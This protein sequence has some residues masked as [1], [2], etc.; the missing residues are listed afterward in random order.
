MSS[1]L[2]GCD[3]TW[4]GIHVHSDDGIPGTLKLSGTIADE[5]VSPTIVSDA[6]IAI[7]SSDASPVYSILYDDDGN[8]IVYSPEPGQVN[9]GKL[10]ITRT[11]FINNLQVLHLQDGVDLVDVS[12]F[13]SCLFEVNDA[14]Y[15]SFDYSDISQ[16][17]AKHVFLFQ[18]QNLD[19]VDCE[20]RNDMTNEVYFPELWL[21][22]GRAIQSVDAKFEVNSSLLGSGSSFSGFYKGIESTN[23][24]SPWNH[25]RIIKSNF[26]DNQIA[27]HFNNVCWHDVIQNTVEVGPSL[28]LPLELQEA[29]VPYEGIFQQMGAYFII[30]EN[31]IAGIGEPIDNEPFVGIRIRDTGARDNEVYRNFL[32]DLTRG[33]QAEGDNVGSTAPWDQFGLRFVCNEF[34]DCEFDLI[35]ANNGNPTELSWEQFGL[36][37]DDQGM[38]LLFEDEEGLEDFGRRG[39]NSFTL[40]TSP[41]LTATGNWHNEGS[42]LAYWCG[43]ESMCPA[44]VDN[45]GLDVSLDDGAAHNCPTIPVELVSGMQEVYFQ[46]PADW[47]L[48]ENSWNAVVE[49]HEYILSAI[50]DGGDSDELQEEV[51]FAWVDDTWVMREDLLSKSPFLSSDV[52]MRVADNTVTF[53]HAIAFEIFAANPD[54]LRDARFMEHLTSKSEPLPNY[55]VDLLYLS[56]DQHTFRTAIESNIALANASAQRVRSLSHRIELL[57][58]EAAMLQLNE[59]MNS[60]QLFD[61]KLKTQALSLAGYHAEAQSALSGASFLRLSQVDVDHLNSWV[62]YINVELTQADWVDPKELTSTQWTALQDLAV[63]QSRSWGGQTAGSFLSIH[64]EDDYYLRPSPVNL[65]PRI[66]DLGNESEYLEQIGLRPNPASYEVTIELPLHWVSNDSKTITVYDLNHRLISVSTLAGHQTNLSLDV[67]TWSSG[68]YLVQA[69]NARTTIHTKLEVIH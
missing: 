58:P 24:N 19:F 17:F 14:L 1:T 22:R 48:L 11:H 50:I 43:D 60:D 41:Q 33:C 2:Q 36:E 35:N 27:M 55:L 59:E 31:T 57:D 29:D 68:L 15:E 9:A 7:S 18:V 66:T 67:S 3:G 42:L 8:P 47:I 4:E 51:E 34:T 25:L 26:T 13:Q 32:F 28:N 56:R 53:P 10:E 21:D 54:V 39:G 64:S 6:R 40:T 69:Q 16:R 44:M 37:H 63:N 30:A 23:T 5:V 49:D 52:L 38:P 65:N 20:F 45:V 12:E 61:L 62:T 46:V